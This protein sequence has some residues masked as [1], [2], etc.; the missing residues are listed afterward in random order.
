MG[1][2]ARVHGVGRCHVGPL[3]LQNVAQAQVEVGEVGDRE[4]ITEF[5]LDAKVDHVER[6]EQANFMRER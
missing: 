6:S 1:G 4:M 5:K 3:L 2:A